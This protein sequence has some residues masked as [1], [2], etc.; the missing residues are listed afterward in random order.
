MAAE[1]SDGLG[2]FLLHSTV[3][4]LA[5]VGIGLAYEALV[6]QSQL[7][8]PPSNGFLSVLGGAVGYVAEIAAQAGWLILPSVVVCLLIRR[9]YELGF[10]LGVVTA[11]AAILVGAGILLTNALAVSKGGS[12]LFSVG[13]VHLV[14]TCGALLL[15]F[16]P[17][18]PGRGKTWTII[19]IVVAAA[20]VEAI[21]AI[22]DAVSL[23]A[24]LGGWLI[25]LTW[26]CVSAWAFRRW[27]RRDGPLPV[28]HSGLPVEDRRALVPVPVREP[29]LPGGGR[30]V[31]ILCGTWLLLA[32][33]V[34]GLG[35]L[36]TGVLSPVRSFDQAVVE[37]F[38]ENRT[39]TWNALATMAGSFGTTGGIIGALIVTGAIFSAATRRGAPTIFLI[40][41][42]V[43]ET[44]LYLITGVIVGRPRPDVDHLSEG[45][46]PTSSFPSGHVAAAVVF[47]GGLAL[48][49][50]AWTR[51][52]LRDLGLILAPLIVL[53]V[54]L[55]RLYWGVHYPSDTI[56][57]L[58]FATVWVWACWRC[59]EPARGA[60]REESQP[61][62]GTR[63][64]HS[65]PTSLQNQK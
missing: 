1:L 49:L 63:R 39:D 21:R 31:L 24:V 6:P 48:L 23:W 61:A 19:G 65:Q 25:G 20:A 53:G 37:W 64:N 41:A 15:V 5:L 47:Y 45:V 40:T 18:I 36:I 56:V 2:R 3:G 29:L 26:L 16:L 13:S 60:S 22:T 11:G 54:L 14:V 44:A 9:L 32:C 52:R 28:L 8:E 12:T 43:G 27:R 4:M 35:L 51:S 59:F 58:L 34:I 42:V 55:S 10:Y 7:S 62:P 33:A 57:S 46:P 50:R 38:A 30:S 17:V